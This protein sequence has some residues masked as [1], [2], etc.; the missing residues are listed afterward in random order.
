MLF[1]SFKTIPD[2]NDFDDRFVKD[3]EIFKN[4]DGLQSASDEG[5]RSSGKKAIRCAFCQKTVT[6]ESQS[7][8]VNGA[9]QH[10]LTNP[11]GLVF[12]IG[13]FKI[14]VG[15]VPA[16]PPSLE[17]TWFPGYSWRIAVCRHCQFH[18]G[19]QFVGEKSQFYGLI[20]DHLIIP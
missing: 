20:L 19:W 2:K 3:R 11:H 13:C 17:F 16:S 9:R 4:K 15:A 7:I 1:I 8:S 5:R 10:L 14:C 12:E 6:D 18:I